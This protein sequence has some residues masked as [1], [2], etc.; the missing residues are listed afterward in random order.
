MFAEAD[1]DPVFPVLIPVV[2]KVWSLDDAAV[3]ELEFE[4]TE[5]WYIVPGFSPVISTECDVFVFESTVL[6]VEYGSEEPYVI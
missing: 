3:P 5:K 2:V 6:V 4:R 1:D